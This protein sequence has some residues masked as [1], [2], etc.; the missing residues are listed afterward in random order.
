MWSD[1]LREQE[2]ENLVS[3]YNSGR[4]PL[5][6]WTPAVIV[7]KMNSL[8]WWRKNNLGLMTAFLTRA[9][10]RALQ[11]CSALYVLTALVESVPVARESF[12]WL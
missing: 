10:D 11:N 1:G 8:K 9:K 3:G 6:R 2:K 12:P 4:T 5:F 7:G